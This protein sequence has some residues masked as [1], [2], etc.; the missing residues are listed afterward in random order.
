MKRFIIV[1]SFLLFTAFNAIAG[2][3]DSERYL[4][5]KFGQ[6]WFLT[7]NATANW[8]QGSDRNPAGNY[9][10]LNGPSFG[11]SLSFGKW[12]THNLGLRLTYDVNQSQSFIS[13][14]LKHQAS[15]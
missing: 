6:N 1:S 12:I 13:F 8:W 14:I 2:G 7:A 4:S 5:S 9:T 10:S 11:G 3:H 15:L